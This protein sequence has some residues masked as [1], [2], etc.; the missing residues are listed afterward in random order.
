MTLTQLI[1]LASDRHLHG[2][3]HEADELGK[4]N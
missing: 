2:E 4:L 1:L 3:R